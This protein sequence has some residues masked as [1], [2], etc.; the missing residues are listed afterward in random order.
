MSRLT[1]FDPTKDTRDTSLNLGGP[2]ALTAAGNE[3][4]GLLLGLVQPIDPFQ[5]IQQTTGATPTID[6]K[7]L[8]SCNRHFAILYWRGSPDLCFIYEGFLRVS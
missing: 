2:G 5:D 6:E 7:N 4:A 1:P 8:D 3:L